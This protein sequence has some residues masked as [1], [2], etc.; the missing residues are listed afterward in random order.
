MLPSIHTSWVR[1]TRPDRCLQVDSQIFSSFLGSPVDLGHVL[2]LVLCD[3]LALCLYL[4]ISSPRR[5]GID[6]IITVPILG[7]FNA[8][9]LRPVSPTVFIN[10]ALFLV[11]PRGLNKCG[12][13]FQKKKKKTKKE[14][15][16]YV[17]VLTRILNKSKKVK[18]LKDTL[19]QTLCYSGLERKLRS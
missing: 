8:G 13:P 2:S 16:L 11:I 6:Q 3:C 7:Q 4:L 5:V 18:T 19:F 12:S 17:S 1:K 10:K 9:K 15:W 14:I